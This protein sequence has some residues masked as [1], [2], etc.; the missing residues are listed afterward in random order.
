MA[1]L[2]GPLMAPLMAPQTELQ[3]EARRLQDALDTP[4][5]IALFAS[6]GEGTMLICLVR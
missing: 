4:H 2:T 5:K 1:Q 6:G 3:T